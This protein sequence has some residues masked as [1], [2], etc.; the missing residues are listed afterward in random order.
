MEETGIQLIHWC[1]AWEEHGIRRINLFEG[2]SLRICWC[3]AIRRT[4]EYGGSI[5]LKT[6]KSLGYGGSTGQKVGRSPETV[7]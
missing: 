1:E 6:G 2:K 3:E 4:P 7:T 5:C